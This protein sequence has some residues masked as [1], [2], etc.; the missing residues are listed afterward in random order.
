[1]E[2]HWFDYEWLDEKKGGGC[3]FQSLDAA[4][5]AIRDLMKE[6]EWDEDVTCWTELTKWIPGENGVMENLYRYYLIRDEIVFFSKKTDGPRALGYLDPYRF[7]FTTED[8][9][10]STPFQPGD[11]VTLDP[12]PFAPPTHAVLLQSHNDNRGSIWL[13][14]GVDGLWQ[15]RSIYHCNGWGDISGYDPILSPIYHLS[16]CSVE[17]LLPNE[18]EVLKLV[19]NYIRGDKERGY[20]VDDALLHSGGIGKKIVQEMIRRLEQEKDYL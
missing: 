13:Y 8:V 10:C 4:L 7:V 20:E 11:I 16:M 2:E 1:M 19:H 12:R 15:N 3:A 6:E 9:C 14:R 18:R 5:Q 17:D